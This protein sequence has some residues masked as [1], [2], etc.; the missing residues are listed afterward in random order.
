MKIVFISKYPPI[1]GYVSSCTYWLARGLASRGHDITVVTNAFEVEDAYREEFRA[2][3][4]DLYQGKRLR[5]RNTDPFQDYKLIPAANPFCEKL[6]AA[7][8][9]A[10]EGADVLDA[11][12][13]VSYG[14]A[15]L[16]AHAAT[17]SPLVIRHAGSDIGRLAANPHMRPLISA[18]L[19][20]A[21]AVVST[22]AGRARLVELGARRSRICKIP[23]SVDTEAFHPSAEKAVLDAPDDVPVISCIGKV[24]R[25]KGVPQLLAAASKVKEDFRLVFVSSDIEGLRRMTVHSGLKQKFLFK[26]FVP[27]WRIPGIIRASRAVIMP[28]HG[29]PV[30][31]HSPILPREVLA[32]GTCL[33]ISDE[34]SGK[35]AGGALSDGENALVVGPARTAD[36][37]SRLSTVIRDEDAARRIGACGHR[38]SARMED[39]EGYLSANER[40][41]RELAR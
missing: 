4:L 13:F 25:G 15:G 29:F 18:M 40:M 7:A 27:P 17:G 9:E 31:G 39:F 20:K 5:V 2:A 26:K 21:D 23:V 41:H 24:S 11:W 6:A 19:R 37:A 10:S 33:V 34:L 16:L 36:F 22:G 8:I 14:S 3:D 38:L 1:E 32:C 28:E 30:S 12:Y 35:V